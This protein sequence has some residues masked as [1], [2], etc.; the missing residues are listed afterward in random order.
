MPGK[1]T[2]AVI[3]L[4]ASGLVTMKNLTE[5]GFD[6]TGFERS[7]SIGGVWSY[8]DTPTKTTVLRSRI[9]SARVTAA[10]SNNVRQICFTDFPHRPETPVYPRGSQMH[11]YLRDYATHFNI[12]GSIETNV[13]VQEIARN[14]EK[15]CWDLRLRSTKSNAANVITRRFDRVVIASGINHIPVVPK[16]KGIEK[17]GGKVIHSQ[18]FKNP[19]EFAGK[20]V[21]VVGLNNSAGDT[22][23]SL[24]GIAGKIYISHRKGTIILKRW[25]RNKP[26]D[27]NISWVRLQIMQ[28]YMDYVPGLYNWSILQLQNKL[29]PK[30]LKPEWKLN[31]DLPPFTQRLPLVN[32]ELVDAMHEKKI[33]PLLNI[34]EVLD[35]DTVRLSDGTMISDLDAIIFSYVCGVGFQMAVFHIYD[36]ASM[37]LAQ[38]WSGNSPLPPVEEMRAQVD[39]HYEWI[40]SRARQGSVHP[41]LVRTPEWYRWVNEAAGTGVYE[42]LGYGV[43]GWR[44]WVGDRAWCNTLMYRIWSPHAYRLFDTGRR[45]RWDGAKQEILRVVRE[46]E[47][48]GNEVGSEKEE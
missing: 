46:I 19:N 11:Q 16:I 43:E 24:L 12:H 31:E 22:A 26:T 8:E 44:F 33:I 6:V 40:L 35:G 45:K 15:D 2:V 9:S 21:L 25:V 5:E 13:D 7:S 18:Q 42:K 30:G 38:V 36:L 41:D 14:D 28:R 23:V 39:A 17:F 27:H 32:D 1:P 34:T 20:Q 48:M 3:G 47:E 37:A 4:G 10:S 29:H